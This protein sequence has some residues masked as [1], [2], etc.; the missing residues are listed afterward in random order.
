MLRRAVLA[1]RA[2]RCGV[3]TGCCIARGTCLV[4]IDLR[5]GD[6]TIGTRAC[7]DKA[8]AVACLL[9]GFVTLMPI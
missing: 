7:L 9:A 3:L 1:I 8:H 5:P 6:P 2:L 4:R